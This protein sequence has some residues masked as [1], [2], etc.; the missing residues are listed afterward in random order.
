MVERAPVSSALPTAAP[1]E[2]YQSS[3]PRLRPP[4]TA[5]T[6]VRTADSDLHGLKSAD[7]PHRSRTGK[8]SSQEWTKFTAYSHRLQAQTSVYVRPLLAYLRSHT[9]E[10]HQILVHIDC[11]YGS[12]PLWRLCDTLYAMYFRF[13]D[14]VILSQDG[15]HSTSCIFLWREHSIIAKPKSMIYKRTKFCSTIKTTYSLFVAHWGNACYLQL[16]YT[17]VGDVLRRAVITIN[18]CTERVNKIVAWRRTGM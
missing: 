4:P 2:V 1:C 13:V 18:R 7:E 15:P 6:A 11:G 10:L 3:T 8:D 14:D 17:E 9:T 5:L 16:H 12:V